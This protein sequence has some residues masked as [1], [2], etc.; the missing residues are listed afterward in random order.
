MLSRTKQLTS[1]FL[2]TSSLFHRADAHTPSTAQPSG[3]LPANGLVR[4]PGPRV[5]V[6]ARSLAFLFNS[7]GTWKR[8]PRE[9]SFTSVTSGQSLLVNTFTAA[10]KLINRPL[11]SLLT[12]RPADLLRLFLRSRTCSALPSFP[13]AAAFYVH[14]NCTLDFITCCWWTRP[15]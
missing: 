10:H 8:F 2:Q 5:R 11:C 14:S 4:N 7:N 6:R 12:V 13:P 3:T 1:V 15:P 9:W